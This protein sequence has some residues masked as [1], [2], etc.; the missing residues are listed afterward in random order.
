MD[1]YVIRKRNFLGMTVTS[2]SRDYGV[3]PSIVRI[4]TTSPVEE[5]CSTGWLGLQADDISRVNS[6]PFEWKEGDGVLVTYPQDVDGK[7]LLSSL[8]TVF[9]G[10]IS[11][12]PPSPLVPLLPNIIAHAGGGQAN[13]VQMNPGMNT[14]VIAASAGDSVRLPDD[15]LS[16]FTVVINR[17]A[18]AV[19]VF[20]FLG[21]SINALAVNTAISVP[22]GNTVM[23]WGGDLTKWNTL[24]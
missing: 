16:Q 10:F 24:S 11:L 6:G 2:I 9:P 17:G 3:N 7:V 12:V 14:I 15:V 19:D 4:T 22:A 20:P 13:A 1:C 8:F 21:D 18:N 5:I 23:F